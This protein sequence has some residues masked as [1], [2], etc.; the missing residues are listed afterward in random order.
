[1]I[2]ARQKKNKM[3]G[4][5]PII[6][7]PTFRG[8]NQKPI[9]AVAT[10]CKDDCHT[11]GKCQK[12]IPA[13]ATNPPLYYYTCIDCQKTLCTEIIIPLYTHQQSICEHDM[14]RVLCVGPKYNA[15]K[16]KLCGF[17]RCEFLI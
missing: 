17:Q 1:M 16:C 10:T 2:S 8:Y 6:P 12:P 7:Y 11:W 14:E 13:V 3:N 5:V 4:G 15:E 9:P